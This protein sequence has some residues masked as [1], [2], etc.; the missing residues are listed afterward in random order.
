MGHC[1]RVSCYFQRQ[2]GMTDLVQL[3]L[4]ARGFC[5]EGYYEDL[6]DLI[7]ANEPSTLQE[8]GCVTNEVRMP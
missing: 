2:G 7:E 8:L 6:L 3:Y 4:T 5:W 1:Y